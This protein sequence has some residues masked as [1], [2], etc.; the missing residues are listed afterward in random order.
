[1]AEDSRPICLEP[2]III[3]I[4]FVLR[5][6]TRCSLYGESVDD[7]DHDHDHD[8]DKTRIAWGGCP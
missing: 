2:P 7:H 6:P 8:V 1:M 5:P 3:V 4:C